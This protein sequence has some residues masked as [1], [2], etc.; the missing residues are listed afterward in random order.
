MSRTLISLPRALPI[1]LAGAIAI[2]LLLPAS[3]L[4][5]QTRKAPEP[6]ADPRSTAMLVSQATD[7]WRGGDSAR[8][9]ALFDIAR[10][11]GIRLKLCLEHFRSL[12]PNSKQ[13]WSQKLLHRT[14]H[15]GPAV[16]MDDFFTNARSRA[17]FAQDLRRFLSAAQSGSGR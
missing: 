7:A 1:Q 12:D 5:A 4:M 9:A 10:R 2:A 17:Q 3:M 15:G 14:D 13:K 6:P 16:D 11:H 8:A